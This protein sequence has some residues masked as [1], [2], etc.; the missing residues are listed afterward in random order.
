MRARSNEPI[1][2]A[3]FGAGGTLA[4]VLLPSIIVVTG[5]AGPLGWLGPDA[6]SHARA[7]AFAQSWFGK[8]FVFGVISLVFWHAFHRIYHS[9]HD[10]GVQRGLGV[11][12]VVSYGLAALA[13][14]TTAI[15]LLRIG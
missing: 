11:F 12:K 13:T 14:L 4:A 6:M 15:T 2:W 7:L 8:L 3:L 10:L 5:V 9:L 1:F